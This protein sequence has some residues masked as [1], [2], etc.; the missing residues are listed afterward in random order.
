MLVGSLPPLLGQVDGHMGYPLSRYYPSCRVGRASAGSSD[1]D[2]GLYKPDVRLDE[3]LGIGHEVTIT[4]PHYSQLV[5]AKS[6]G[7]SGYCGY[8][9]PVSD[10]LFGG[11]R[12]STS[13][14]LLTSVPICFS[15]PSPALKLPKIK[16]PTRDDATQFPMRRRAKRCYYQETCT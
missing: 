4:G 16:S 7:G 1:V 13:F 10:E 12:I 8:S 6:T 9:H 15:S 14:M 2:Q 11:E 5:I 3:S